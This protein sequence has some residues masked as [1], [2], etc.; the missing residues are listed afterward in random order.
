[1]DYNPKY[2]NFRNQLTAELENYLT[3]T[4][5]PRMSGGGDIFKSTPYYGPFFDE[6]YKPSAAYQEK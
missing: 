5:D 1:M 2:Q 3:K 4:N 6:E